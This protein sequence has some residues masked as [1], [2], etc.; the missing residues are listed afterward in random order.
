[1]SSLTSESSESSE[2]LTTI[3]FLSSPFES[4]ES[5]SSDKRSTPGVFEREMIL[6]EDFKGA[7]SL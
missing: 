5:G 6:R 4:S 7:K 2:S 1:M 3:G